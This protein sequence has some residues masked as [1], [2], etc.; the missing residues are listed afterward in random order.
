[1]VTNT[2][3]LWGVPKCNFFCLP[4]HDHMRTPRMVTRTVFLAIHLVMHWRISFFAQVS[5][6]SLAP[7]GTYHFTIQSQRLHMVSY[8]LLAFIIIHHRFTIWGSY[9]NTRS[10]IQSISFAEASKS[11]YHM[12]Q[13]NQAI[14]AK[15]AIQDN[16]RSKWIKRTYHT[17]ILMRH[18]KHE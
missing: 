9:C 14:D 17:T 7:G 3:W 11:S 16:I 13:A 4:L 18:H 15:W 12:K 2:L 5:K 10:V 6:Y 1:M 8:H